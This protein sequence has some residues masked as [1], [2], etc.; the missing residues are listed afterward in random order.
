MFCSTGMLPKWCVTLFVNHMV[1]LMGP[2][3]IL[4]I[5]C[6]TQDTC[7]KPALNYLTIPLS[8]SYIGSHTSKVQKW[9]DFCHQHFDE[10]IL[11]IEYYNWGTKILHVLPT[12]HLFMITI[13]PLELKVMETLVNCLHIG[14][15]KSAI[16]KG[17]FWNENVYFSMQS[18]SVF[19]PGALKW[20]LQVIIQTKLMLKI[21]MSVKYH[22]MTL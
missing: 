9:D 5:Y 12:R 16:I 4:I 3:P 6:K 14:H 18:S 19:S 7:T 11:I 13:I 10:I 20:N 1:L 8:G 21:E 22:R 15:L 2:C 17:T